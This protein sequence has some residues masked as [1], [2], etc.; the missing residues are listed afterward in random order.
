VRGSGRDGSISDLYV[1]N[2][3]SVTFG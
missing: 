3:D 2:G 1:G